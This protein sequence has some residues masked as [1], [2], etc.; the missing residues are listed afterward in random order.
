MNQ[1]VQSFYDWY[2]KT[3]K[4][5]KYR[6]VLVAGTL[7]YLIS[8]IDISPDF[9]PIIGWIDDAAV[10]SLLVAELSQIFLMRL[11]KKRATQNSEDFGTTATTIDVNPE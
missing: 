10:A 3:I 1:P 4:H 5:P 2:Q 7:I 9:I 8:P 11:T 6:W